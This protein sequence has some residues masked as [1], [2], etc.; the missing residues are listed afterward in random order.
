MARSPARRSEAT[1]DGVVVPVLSAAVGDGPVVPVLGPT[2]VADSSVPVL[3]LDE[4]HS[5]IF[6]FADDRTTYQSFKKKRGKGKTSHPREKQKKTDKNE[7]SADLDDWKRR[8]AGLVA[9]DQS[10]VF[11]SFKT[12]AALKNSAGAVAKRSKAHGLAGRRVSRV[13]LAVHHRGSL[14]PA[15]I[16]AAGRRLQRA[17]ID[18]TIVVAHRNAGD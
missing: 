17:G 14:D 6:G 9:P 10:T 7:S 3:N 8:V 15:P 1:G 2:A 13:V 4:N 16:V 11:H 18:A 12:L 5:T